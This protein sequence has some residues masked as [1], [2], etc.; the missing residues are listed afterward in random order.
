[1]YNLW[2]YVTVEYYGTMVLLLFAAEIDNND[3][4]F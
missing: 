4:K 3:T 2:G 1:M